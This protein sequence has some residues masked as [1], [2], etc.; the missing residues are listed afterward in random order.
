V[1]K[2]DLTFTIIGGEYRGKKLPLPSKETTRAT[3]SIIR[4]SVFDTLQ[5]EI[6]DE[7]FVELFG[8]SGSMGLEALSR[9]AGRVYF[10]ERDK[11]ACRVLEQNSAALDKKRTR[12]I[13]G[14]SFGQFPLLAQSLKDQGHK[15]FIYIDPPFDIREGME[16]IYTRTKDLIAVIPPQ[17][18]H[19][20]IVEHMSSVAFDDRIGPFVKQKSKKFG[21]TTVTYYTVA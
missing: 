11:A 8:G 18:V 12:L 6:V 19:R 7:I 21:K 16:D 1:K 13:C 20:V 15:A 17:I 4:G 3:K 14:D 2:R 10:F 5:F 9:G